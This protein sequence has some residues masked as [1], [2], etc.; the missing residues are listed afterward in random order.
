MKKAIQGLKLFQREKQLLNVG[1]D[2]IFE[3]LKLVELN[4]FDILFNYGDFGFTY[5]IVLKGELMLLQPKDETQMQAKGKKAEP[6]KGNPVNAPASQLT[7]HGN[8]AQQQL[9][10]PNTPRNLP[11]KGSEV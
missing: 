4:K 2:K 7:V 9:P 5:Y 10:L 8:N 11:Q 1:S 6:D 3:E